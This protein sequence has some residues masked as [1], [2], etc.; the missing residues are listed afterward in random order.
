MIPSKY[1]K[2]FALFEGIKD[3]SMFIKFEI[4]AYFNSKVKLWN[5]NETNKKD[6]SLF[7]MQKK[8][9]RSQ[10]LQQK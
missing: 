10:I 8:Q 2:I 9:P 5:V 6:S 3:Y 1:I 4:K 7:L